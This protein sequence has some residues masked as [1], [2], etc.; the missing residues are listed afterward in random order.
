MQK[1]TL[2]LTPLLYCGQQWDADVSMYYLRARYYRSDTGRFWTM[3]TYEGDTEDPLS[4]HKYLYC[5]D[6]PVDGFDPGGHSQSTDF[7]NKV[8]DVITDEFI[9]SGKVGVRGGNRAIGTMVD[10]LSVGPLRLRPD[11]YQRNDGDTT[12]AGNFFFEIKST[13]PGEIA[14]GTSKVALYNGLLNHYGIWH[15]GSSL[16]YFFWK[17]TT[18]PIISTDRN[19]N[20]LPGGCIAVVLPPAGGLMLYLKIDPKKVPEPFID[21]IVADVEAFSQMSTAAGV[22][23]E[24]AELNS[25]VTTV[26]TMSATATAS[27]G[28]GMTM[29]VTIQA[30]VGMGSVLA[31]EGAY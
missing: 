20:L 4:L 27:T 3:D 12:G 8:Q 13:D 26:S 18:G 25:I 11:L 15:P 29:T 5:Q 16:D 22:A 14:K 24:V 17:R 19:G 2:C 1:K 21:F 10:E 9:D 23:T 6:G 30:D 31:E 28:V 7:G